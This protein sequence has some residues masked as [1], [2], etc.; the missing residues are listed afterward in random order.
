MAFV[1]NSLFCNNCG[2]PLET[3]GSCKMCPAGN[4][5]RKASTDKID[6]TCPWN[7]HGNI[8]GL[9]GSM[10]DST[11]GA[12]P[13][14]CSRHFWILKGWPDK[15]RSESEATIATQPTFRERWYTE[16]GLPYQSPQTAGTD[17]LLPMAT[18]GPKTRQPGED[19]DYIQ[20]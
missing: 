18:L 8:C 1:K 7:D 4:P 14:Y 9:I 20:P 5:R 17:T 12:G 3:D 16:H 6:R 13:W 11:N 2:N 15:S 19:D 10:S